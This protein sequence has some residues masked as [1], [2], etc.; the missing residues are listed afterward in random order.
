VPISGKGGA[1]GT[2]E[3]CSRIDQGLSDTNWSK[4]MNN[5]M[6]YNGYTGSVAFDAEEV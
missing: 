1:K 4:T 6:K 5:A 2:A 3:I